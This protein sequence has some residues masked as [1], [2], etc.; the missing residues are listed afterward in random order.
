MQIDL[1]ASDPSLPTDFAAAKRLARACRFALEEAE[2]N[3]FPARSF[4]AQVPGG[5]SVTVTIS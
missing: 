4:T 3:P 1:S 5:P 2:K